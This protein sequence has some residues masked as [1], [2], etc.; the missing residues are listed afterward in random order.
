MYGRE[1]KVKLTNNM[2]GIY[3]IMKTIQRMAALASHFSG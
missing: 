3:F 1:I 2:G